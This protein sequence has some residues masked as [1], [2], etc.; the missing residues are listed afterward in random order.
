MKALRDKNCKWIIKREVSGFMK[1]K[2]SLEHK[3][4]TMNI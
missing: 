2:L 1:I 4:Y 3:G